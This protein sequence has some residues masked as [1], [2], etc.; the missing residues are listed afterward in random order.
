MN[1]IQAASTANSSIAD[2]TKTTAQV[3][4]VP[5]KRPGEVPELVDKPIAWA[6][7]A[8]SSVPPKA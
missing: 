5:K 6:I 8:S 2:E 4:R 7:R 1:P 3:N